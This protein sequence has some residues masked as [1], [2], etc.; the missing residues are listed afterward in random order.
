[1]EL[2]DRFSPLRHLD[3]SIDAAAWKSV[4]V[5]DGLIDGRREVARIEVQENARMILLR[6]TDAA[7][8]VVTFDLLGSESP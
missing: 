5:E 8:N 4:G 3:Y 2:G 7:F 6:A 1:M